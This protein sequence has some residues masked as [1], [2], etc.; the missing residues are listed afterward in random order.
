MLLVQLA[1]IHCFPLMPNHSQEINIQQ[2]TDKQQNTQTQIELLPHAVIVCEIEKQ[3]MIRVQSNKHQNR[4]YTAGGRGHTV[5]N[6]FSNVTVAYCA[7][8][9]T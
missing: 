8:I 6:L 5:Q 9:V 3:Q 4:T 7:F 1:Y 2:F